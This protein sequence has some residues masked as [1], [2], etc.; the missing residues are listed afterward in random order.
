MAS[1]TSGE[2]AARA[3]GVKSGWIEAVIFVLTI[4]LLNLSYASAHA[5]GAHPVA[6]LV[7]AM[8]IAAVAL[9]AVT[10]AGPQAVA[11]MLAPQSW[12]VGVGIISM[13]AFYFLL[14][15]YATPAEA[16]VLTRIAIPIAMVMGLLL[17]LRRPARAEIAGAAIVTGGIAWL[18]LGLE[19]SRATAA[20]LLAFAS[21]AVMCG[22]TFVTEFHP[23]NRKADTVSEKMRV[24]GLVLLVTS[25]ASAVLVG[26]LMMLAAAVSGHRA[27]AWLPSVD[28]FLHLPTFLV[29]LLVGAVVLTAM[30]YLAFSSVVKIGTPNFIAATAFTPLTTLIAEQLVSAAG[31]MRPMP[32][33]WHLWPSMILVMAGVFVMLWATEARAGP[34]A[35]TSSPP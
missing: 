29:A 6:F 13:E 2:A 3:R 20:V 16:S 17:G 34:P 15:W 14:L 19:P 27:V 7:Y 9:V 21:A 5:V 23:W 10:G 35:Q 31:L 28:D 25:G 33:D 26:G 11:I 18:S 24:T 8:L 4:A 1:S 22:R 30:Q 32:I 12:L